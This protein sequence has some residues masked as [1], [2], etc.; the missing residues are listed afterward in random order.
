MS[1][2]PALSASISAG[3][4]LKVACLILVP[5]NCL[6]EEALLEADQCGG[7]GQVREVAD[8]HLVGGELLGARRGRRGR[9]GGVVVGLGRSRSR[10]RPARRAGSAAR[11]PRRRVCGAGRSCRRWSGGGQTRGCPFVRPGVSRP[12]PRARPEERQVFGS[13]A[14][15]CAVRGAGVRRRARSVRAARPGASAR[16]SC[17]PA[18]TRAERAAADA[19]AL[20]REAREGFLSRLS[21]GQKSH[22]SS[23]AGAAAAGRAANAS[24]AMPAVS[25]VP[26]AG[27]ISRNEP[28]SRESA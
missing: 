1:I 13:G 26:S 15:G 16:T 3:P 23:A 7:V 21:H 6:L 24:P 8:L 17:H 25:V 19:P 12:V 11:R 10:R 28:V 18:R 20:L 5:P 27:S 2:A 4:A 9:C 22:P 14:A